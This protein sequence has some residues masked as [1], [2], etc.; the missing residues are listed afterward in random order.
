[1]SII[2][3]VEGKLKL[4]CHSSKPLLLF[5]IWCRELNPLLSYDENRELQ[6]KFQISKILYL[7]VF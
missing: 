6:Q 1:M 4:S 3:Q 5:L 7:E 2:H